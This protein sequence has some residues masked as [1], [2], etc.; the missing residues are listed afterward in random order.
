MELAEAR[1]GDEGAGLPRP[2]GPG[3]PAGIRARAGTRTRTRTRD[4]RPRC[5]RCT[6]V[7][8]AGTDR[9]C[10]WTTKELGFDAC[11]N[12]RRGEIGE[13]FRSACLRGIDVY[14]DNVVGEILNTVLRQINIGAQ[15]VV[16][17][18]ISDYNSIEDPPPGP[19]NY[20]ELVNKR[21][22]MEGFL[23]ID[24]VARFGEAG[25]QLG[26]WLAEGKIKS[27]EHIVEGLDRAPA[28]LRMLFDGENMGRMIVRVAPERV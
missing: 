16:C 18:G 9:K 20:L 25:A 17:G 23:I 15:I 19:L 14:Y 5:P 13:R 11:I 27:R 4:L 1:S 2:R 6:V 28:A 22:R 12:Y 26:Q 24:Y 3:F 8:I 10:A 7:G 21:A